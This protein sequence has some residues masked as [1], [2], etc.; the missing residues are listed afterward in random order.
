VSNLHKCLKDITVEGKT[1][2]ISLYKKIVEI[3]N[4]SKKWLNGYG[5][6]GFK[7]SQQLEDILDKIISNPINSDKISR[8]EIFILLAAVYLHDIGY[9]N[10]G[11][12]DPKGH[13]QRSRKMILDDP[14]KYKFSDFLPYDNGPPLVAQAVAQVCLGHAKENEV[15]LNS[16]T[17]NF[18]DQILPDEELNLRKLSSLLR[19][20]DEADDQYSRPTIAKLAR[21]NIPKVK[22]EHAIV[23]TYIV[24][25]S[26]KITQDLIYEKN[27]FLLSSFRYLESK[28]MLMSIRSKES[29]LFKSP[30]I[31]DL[32]EKIDSESHKELLI[33]ELITI[34][35]SH[36]IDKTANLKRIDLDLPMKYT[37]FR[38]ICNCFMDVSSE[39]KHAI[40]PYLTGIFF[41]LVTDP[42]IV[43]DKTLFIK[44]LNS[45]NIFFSKCHQI[46][47]NQKQ[48]IIEEIQQIASNDYLRLMNQITL[49]K[50][51]QLV[52]PNKNSELY[53][54]INK[55]FNGIIDN[56]DR[57]YEVYKFSIAIKNSMFITQFEE[58]FLTLI[59]ELVMIL[60][61]LSDLDIGDENNKVFLDY[62]NDLQRKLLCLSS[63]LPEE[64]KN[65]YIHLTNYK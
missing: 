53:P 46:D 18:P 2:R 45:G 22:I 58:K 63:E 9:C 19:V 55:Q 29:P 40:E 64:T 24:Q 26:S 33:D 50:K 25:E 27:R 62:C 11:K 49:M 12:L 31:N 15:P 56:Y 35:S 32:L 41:S 13:P 61:N 38:K 57:L 37:I 16:I 10:Q 17:E 21:T 48:I 5:K 14:G 1:G 65:K 54:V 23:I 3:K 59:D 39:S 6:N 28:K 42:D 47:Q 43:S 60:E 7:H 52:N 51:I 36:L 44:L 8:S 30:T 4:S 20:V 34:L